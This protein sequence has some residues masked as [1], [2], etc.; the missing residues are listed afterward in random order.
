MPSGNAYGNGSG[1][2]RRHD[3]R[4]IQA[5]KLHQLVA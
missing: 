4:L 2:N 3:N 1:A 5:K